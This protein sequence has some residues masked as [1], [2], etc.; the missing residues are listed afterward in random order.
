[1]ATKFVEFKPAWSLTRTGHKIC[2]KE[3]ET[4]FLFLPKKT[5][6][7]RYDHMAV[8]IKLNGIWYLCDI[9]WGGFMFEGA[10]K[11]STEA[12]E[13]KRFVA[14]C[15]Q[16]WELNFILDEQSKIYRILSQVHLS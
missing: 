5:L 15:V 1:M 8:G 2:A 9:G 11:I 14:R 10:V 3:I 6:G 7:P 16:E 4:I 12:T 13:S